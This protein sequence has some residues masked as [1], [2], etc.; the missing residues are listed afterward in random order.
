LAF[1][2]AGLLFGAFAA[3]VDDLG[4][5]IGE[6]VDDVIKNAGM[7]W[8]HAALENVNKIPHGLVG[9]LKLPVNLQR[10]ILRLRLVHEFGVQAAKGMIAHHIIPLQAIDEFKELMKRGAKGGFDI[11]GLENGQLVLEGAHVGMD[12]AAHNL[13]ILRRLEDIWDNVTSRTTNAEIAQ[14]LRELAAEYM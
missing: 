11:N 2:G 10:A 12:H 5:A 7:G 6:W 14:T 1:N 4:K 8:V 9:Q 3:T 13:R